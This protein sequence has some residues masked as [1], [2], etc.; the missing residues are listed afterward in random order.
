MKTFEGSD[1]EA[2][3]CFFF[4]FHSLGSH[5]LTFSPRSF[6]VQCSAS[7]LNSAS[8]CSVSFFVFYTTCCYEA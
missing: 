2:E 6:P 3:C 8:S 5:S 1:F 7:P 4:F